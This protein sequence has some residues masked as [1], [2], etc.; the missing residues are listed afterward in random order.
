MTK[1]F[2]T[3]CAILLGLSFVAPSNA[4]VVSD[5][6]SASVPVISQTDAVRNQ[7]ITKALQS[8]LVKVSGNSK[9]ISVPQISSVLQSAQN[10][11]HE[12]SYVQADEGST[13]PLMLQVNFNENSI[14]QILKTAGQPI[15]Q[16]NRPLT[17]IWMVVKDANS[18]Y[19]V[20][21]DSTQPI[22]ALLK[23][24]MADRGLPL[25]FPIFDLSDTL[26]VKV[27]D[28]MSLNPSAIFKASSR[29]SPDAI[30]L[31]YID[32]T[33]TSQISGRWQL[34]IQGQKM[35]WET[36]GA[37]LAGVLQTGVN[38]VADALSN[39]Y[40]VSESTA[41]SG[42]LTLIVSNLLGVS[43]YAH[44]MD[45][46]N[47]VASVANLQS[48]NITPDQATFN[49]TIKGEVSSFLQTL[50]LDGQLKSVVNTTVQNTEGQ[51]QTLEYQ[52]T[53]KTGGE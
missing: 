26:Q 19:F 27:N 9:V 2:T 53:G 7:A 34:L 31:I 3:I 10:Y 17:L 18:E 48:S 33:N 35:R 50:R 39:R 47:G 28:V 40:A 8:V 16:A 4:A 44:V 15:W 32:A 1:I 49:L 21:E 6:Y 22:A 25:I 23:Q 30:L 37:D 46:L 13:P 43:D 51:A 11:V 12:Y 14:K 24:A 42:Q 29:Y 52:Y 41:T 38:D 45:Y 5:L 20:H 36:D